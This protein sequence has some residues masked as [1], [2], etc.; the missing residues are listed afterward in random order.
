MLRLPLAVYSHHTVLPRVYLCFPHIACSVHCALPSTLKSSRSTLCSSSCFIY[1]PG[2][3]ISCHIHT[4]SCPHSSCLLLFTPTLSVHHIFLCSPV[5][6]ASLCCCTPGFPFMSQVCC[7]IEKRRSFHS[8]G[9]N[10]SASL[11]GPRREGGGEKETQGE[12]MGPQGGTEPFWSWEVSSVRCLRWLV[13]QLRFLFC[14]LLF[15]HGICFIINSERNHFV[16]LPSPP[17]FFIL[18]PLTRL[19]ST[20]S[21]LHDSFCRSCFPSISHLW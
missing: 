17:P 3:A 2:V 15:V 8:D 7:S 21:V 18:S 5:P 10:G 9:Q 12:E 20:Y 6:R 19:H 16:S 1:H 14:F 11:G 4:F 13:T